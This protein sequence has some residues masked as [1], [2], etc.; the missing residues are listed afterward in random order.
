[1]SPNSGPAAIV[2][3]ESL[4]KFPAATSGVLCNASYVIISQPRTGS[5]L[6][7]ELLRTRGLGNPDEYLHKDR[8]RVWWPKL[9]GSDEAFDLQRYVD[10]LR[11]S[12]SGPSGH[13]GIK[14]HYSQLRE[15]LA[16]MAAIRRFVVAFDKI[17]VLTR[18]NKLAQAISALKAQQT[19]RWGAAAPEVNVGPSFDPAAIAENLRRFL[20]QD[21]QIERLNVATSRPALLVSYEELRDST[22]ETWEKIQS[23]LGVRPEPVPSKMQTRQQRDEQSREFEERF[24]K[25]IRGEP[26]AD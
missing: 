11:Q 8:I 13:F 19:G 7:S 17:I 6:L 2:G 26:V 9:T 24:L 21:R 18:A 4:G 16:D 14:T 5:T 12:Q 10:L 15:C 1:M 20:F 23:F 3:G 22:G 25:L